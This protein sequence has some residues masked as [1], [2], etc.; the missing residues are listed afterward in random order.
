M[1]Q[2]VIDNLSN[3]ELGIAWAEKNGIQPK[4]FDLYSSRPWYWGRS[5]LPDIMGEFKSWPCIQRRCL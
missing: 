4:F 1:G 5:D 2:E 3:E